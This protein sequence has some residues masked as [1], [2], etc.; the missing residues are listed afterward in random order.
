[1]PPTS[2]TAKP[3]HVGNCCRHSQ[4]SAG[5][6]LGCPTATA[7][8]WCPPAFLALASAG[9]QAVVVLIIP[10]FHSQKGVARRVHGQ[11][12]RRRRRVVVP[13]ALSTAATR[14]RILR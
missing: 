3:R 10:L 6:M 9:I 8:W 2:L 13:D 1:M 5:W 12:G 4:Q 14:K 11:G 7:Y